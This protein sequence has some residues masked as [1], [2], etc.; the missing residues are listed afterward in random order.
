MWVFIELAD[1]VLSGNTNQVT[2]CTE[3]HP[4]VPRACVCVCVCLSVSVHGSVIRG[5]SR[6]A[7]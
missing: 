6:A 1:D 7:E 2:L 4:H 3:A 5:G